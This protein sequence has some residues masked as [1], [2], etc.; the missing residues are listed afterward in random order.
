MLFYYD[1]GFL[2]IKTYDF[3]TYCS[4]LTRTKVCCFYHLLYTIHAVLGISSPKP[5]ASSELLQSPYVI[6]LTSCLAQRTKHPHGK[7]IL[8]Y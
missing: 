1:I 5:I 7:E 4:L 6:F 2:M 8:I 3:Q